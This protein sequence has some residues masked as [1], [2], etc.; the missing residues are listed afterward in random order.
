[1]EKQ[2]IMIIAV[3]PVEDFIAQARTARDLWFGSFLLSELGRTAARCLCQEYNAK[4]AAPYLAGGAAAEQPAMLHRGHHIV[5]VI[6]AADPREAALKVRRA[7]VLQWL[8]YAGQAKAELAGCIS[9]EMWERQ[10]KDFIEVFAAWTLFQNGQGYAEALGRTEQLLASRQTLRDFRAN[11]PAKLFGDTKSSLYAGRESVL[12]ANAFA[13]YAKLGIA[14]GEH[15]DAVSLTKRLSRFMGEPRSLR[16]C[17]DV[18][19]HAFRE[20]LREAGNEW[21]RDEAAR[22]AEAVRTLGEGRM[23]LREPEP[24]KA[25]CDSRFFYNELV[26]EAVA[27]LSGPLLPADRQQ[28]IAGLM[29]RQLAQL[30]KTIRQQPSPYYAL[31]TGSMDQPGVPPGS[32]DSPE[33]HQAFMRRLALLALDTEAIAEQA[34]GGQMIYSGGDAFMAIVPVQRCLEAVLDI[35]QAFTAAMEKAVPDRQSRP[36]LSAGMA[37][38]HIREPLAEALRR[39]RLAEERAKRQG[40]GLALHNSGRSGGEGRMIGLSFSGHGQPVECLKALQRLCREGRPVSS[41]VRGLRELHDVYADLYKALPAWREQNNIGHLLYKEIR[42][43]ERRM[44]PAARGTVQG[45]AEWLHIIFGIL[46]QAAGSLEALDRLN[47]LAEL[48]SLA[49]TLE[50]AGDRDEANLSDSTA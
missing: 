11:E 39:V 25:L 14:K 15:L 43:L 16:T 2:W 50:G 19:F 41:Y 3:G 10:V 24:A 22:Y 27:E 32:L 8:K 45:D 34:H 29:K 46:T 37:I 44:H 28:E 35:R 12:Y 13:G 6:T 1:M 30:Y 4:L 40:D 38:A 36:T 7:V 31:L 18:A 47:T 21:R 17:C 26:D 49:I 5:G 20:K 33:Q 48:C 42:Q 23:A 9:P